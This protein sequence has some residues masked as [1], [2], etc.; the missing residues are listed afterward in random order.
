MKKALLVLAVLL[1]PLSAH[2]QISFMVGP[3]GGDVYNSA[4]GAVA[5]R[6]E[7]PLGSRFEIQGD[8]QISPYLGKESLGSGWGYKYGLTGRWWFTPSWSIDGEAEG[9]QYAVTATSKTEYFSQFGFSH[10]QL[11]FGVP[12][13]FGFHYVREFANGLLPNGDETNHL[14]GGSVTIDSRF[15]C[16]WKMCIRLYTE[17]QGGAVENQGNPVCDGSLGGPITCRRT[18]S[19]GGG[20]SMTLYFEFPRRNEFNLF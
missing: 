14:N 11:W 20:A 9:S 1:C 4:F 3:S 8:G 18:W 2:G 19:D 10:R 16:T 5:G 12:T 13:R 15:G 17:I 7:I 6:V